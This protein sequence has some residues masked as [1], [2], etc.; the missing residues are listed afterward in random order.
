ME[1]EGDSGCFSARVAAPLFFTFYRGCKFRFFFLEYIRRTG[2]LFGSEKVTP[3]INLYFLL[4][5]VK[6][7]ERAPTQSR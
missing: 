3:G 6:V 2:G 1:I 5:E 7:A 4:E